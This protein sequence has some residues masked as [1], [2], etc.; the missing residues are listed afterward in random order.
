MLIIYIEKQLDYLNKHKTKGHMKM[1]KKKQS[2]VSW[3]NEYKGIKKLGDG[4]N[5]TV[6][7]VERKTDKVNFA[8]KVLKQCTNP[9]MNKERKHRFNTEVKAVQDYSGAIKGII[10]IVKM[11]KNDYWYVMPVATD[12]MEYIR[13]SKSNISDI[14]TGTIQLC[15]TL[16]A[17]HERG[18]SHRDIK[19]S[20]LYFYDNRYCFSDF[21]LVS[22]PGDNDR[23]TRADKGL[24]AIFTIAPEMKRNPKHSDG[25]K[26][27]VF[28][29]AKT[30]WML[31]SGNDKGFD[32]VYDPLDR[33]HSLSFIE[34]YRNVHLAEIHELLTD[35]TD[36]DPDKRPSIPQFK[37][38][39]QEWL[40]INSDEERSQISD[41]HFLD[42]QIFGKY[43]PESASWR[44][45]EKI[46]NVLNIIG[47]APAFNHMLFST[48]GGLDFEYAKLA[49]EKSC[50]E[51][52]ADGFCHI[53]K[54]KQLIYESFGE[55]CDW[56]YF[57]LEFDELK[58]ILSQNTLGYERLVEDY[59]G[60]YVTAQYAQYGVYDYDSGEP[61]PGGFRV[62]NRYNGGKFLIVM[63]TGPYNCIPETY[64]GRHG[65]CDCAEFRKYMETLISS[66]KRI[67]NI[68]IQNDEMEGISD[69]V[70]KRRI[71]NNAGLGKNPFTKDQTDFSDKTERSKLA[72]DKKASLDYLKNN[73][74]K[75]C[76]IDGF[77][78]KHAENGAMQFYF[79]V[80]TTSYISIVSFRDTFYC[81]G[82]DG[83][84]KEVKSP[85]E[86]NCFFVCDRES[87][88]LTKKKFEE[89]IDSFLVQNS[90]VPL[91]ENQNLIRIK[92]VK[93]GKPTHLFT[94]SEIEATMR[95]ADDRVN[96]QLVID[97][98][99]FAKIVDPR[100]GTLYPVRHES[101][102]AGNGY[103]GRYS[104]LST[105]KRDY[106]CSLQCWL[107]YLKTGKIHHVD[108]LRDNIDV[109][110]LLEEI[111][112]YY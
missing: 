94:L 90:L 98:N 70:L 73:Y 63:K 112:K 93:T 96:N 5:G 107:L 79:E 103:V 32:G 59:P 100:E 64:D 43:S 77:T 35:A 80:M 61:L 76:F 38:R 102:N 39:L 74:K 9:K 17:L 36:N 44:E 75:M 42:K 86:K 89:I 12:I 71:L 6:Y 56:N 41:W 27:D 108:Y 15:E 25:K 23:F 68:A 3:S 58:P 91:A 19:P 14:V 106:L 50:I 88:V 18:I 22:V 20:N 67:Y 60:H 45:P 53:A 92:P 16:G 1:N 101:W 104:T 72:S 105:A 66:F 11:S 65:S 82:E 28:S 83:Y 48:K 62:V 26:A 55:D 54:P 34:E 7:L 99:G 69:K 31:L 110:S 30:M 95:A 4:G 87:A 13:Q 8:L 78:E 37:N 46:V 29:L 97:E 85:L 84:I 81:I 21:G 47:T 49:K 52:N 109:Q 40:E 33:S 111:K 51:I 10:P 57:L 24:G 2:K